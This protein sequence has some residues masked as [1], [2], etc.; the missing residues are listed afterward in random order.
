MPLPTDATLT[1]THIVH[2][3][4]SVPGFCGPLNTEVGAWTGVRNAGPSSVQNT[5]RISVIT[6]G[7]CDVHADS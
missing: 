3:P 6:E 4:R 7:Q 2:Y 5:A 1:Q